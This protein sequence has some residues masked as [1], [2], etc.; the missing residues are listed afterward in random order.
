MRNVNV[1]DM[2]SKGLETYMRSHLLQLRN[3]TDDAQWNEIEVNEDNGYAVRDIIGK[4][5]DEIRD[6]GISRGVFAPEIQNSKGFEAYYLLKLLKGEDTH[7]IET[8]QPMEVDKESVRALIKQLEK[9]IE[10]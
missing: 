9:L 3:I 10:K 8:K 4:A 5:E 1:Q 7:S 2:L 6:L